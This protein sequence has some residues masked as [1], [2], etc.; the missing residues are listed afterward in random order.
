M[1]TQR[2]SVTLSAETEVLSEQPDAPSKAANSSRTCPHR[3]ARWPSCA[4]QFAAKSAE[5]PCHNFHAWKCRPHLHS[6]AVSP[7]CIQSRR[8]ETDSWAS[9]EM[10]ASGERH[11]SG[12]KCPHHL[13][14]NVLSRRALA[15]VSPHR[16]PGCSAGRNALS[17]MSQL[18]DQS[19]PWKDSRWV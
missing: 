12:T 16:V 19:R 6:S 14:R 9:R 3:P 7:D 13:R 2:Y 5:T 1:T 8:C 17:N 18:P 15:P 10:P 4:V 11:Y